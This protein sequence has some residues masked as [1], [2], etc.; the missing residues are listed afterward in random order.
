MVKDLE[1]LRAKKGK[2]ENT[3]TNK[4]RNE[5]TTLHGFMRPSVLRSLKAN[6]LVVLKSIIGGLGLTI[7]GSG[8][9]ILGGEFLAVLWNVAW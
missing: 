5:G 3:A 4:E 6:R 9:I 2:S 7:D 1:K 8:F